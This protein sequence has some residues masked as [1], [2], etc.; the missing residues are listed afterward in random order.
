MEV[1]IQPL[2][3]L[4]HHPV[5]YEIPRFQRQYVWNQEAQWDPLWEDIQGKAE[6]YLENGKPEEHFLGAIVLQQK[7]FPAGTMELRNVVDGQQRL[8][9]LQ[10]LLNTMKEVLDEF[11][12]DEA[13]SRLG[14]LI[15]N[16]K[17]HCGN[18][19]DKQLKIK[20]TL[21]DTNPFRNVMSK[22]TNNIEYEEEPLI[23]KASKFFQLQI[24]Q[25]LKD[26][27]DI[28]ERI[29]ALE[30]VIN[31]SIKLIVI[32][33]KESDDPHI[34]FETLNARGTPL[35]Q[36]DLIKNM[37][38]YE[39]DKIGNGQGS[40]KSIDQILS[41]QDD[42]WRK[43]IRQGRVKRPRVDVYLFYWMVMRR[44]DGFA[45]EKLFTRF[46]SYYEENNDIHNLI[47][48][49]HS[50]GKIYRAYEENPIPSLERFVYRILRTMQVGTV[51][52][53]LLRLLSSK[54][55]ETQLEESLKALE[56]YLLRRMICRMNTRGYDRLFINLLKELNRIKAEDIS[57]AIIEYLANQQS[58]IGLW[59]SDKEFDHA[60]ISYPLY[61]HLTRGRLRIFLEG[62][63]EELR[64]IKAETQSVPS[65]LTIEHIM[66]QHWRHHWKLPPDSQDYIGEKRDHI[67][68]TIG[69]LTLVNHRLNATLSN[70]PWNTKRHTLDQHTTLFINKNLLENAP[71]V[72]DEDTIEERSKHLCEVAKKVWPRPT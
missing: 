70:D 16:E 31:K 50:V 38:L 4:F 68:H 20:P 36:S 24:R 46:K 57:S 69:N 41:F 2:D 11:D 53:I 48:D 52:P 51:N 7:S 22:T 40:D 54:L 34:I 55:S 30:L 43:E 59:P 37:L 44:V 19:L 65:G 25:F 72:W 58:S 28:T 6:A 23:V 3:S 64:T 33:L 60:L 45:P 47:D 49:M 62:I 9:T 13:S 21:N 35:L 14:D 39:V 71:D 26:Q 42:W 63:E 15:K 67:I 5:C 32:D 12:Y 1:H 8:I 56:S 17:R 29:K 18:D 27:S 10:I 66:P 61:K